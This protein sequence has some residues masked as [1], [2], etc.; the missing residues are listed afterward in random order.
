[1]D[2][3]VNHSQADIAANVSPSS[4]DIYAS[5]N[6]PD[7]EDNHGTLV[8]GVIGAGFNGFGTIGV[9]Y[10]S[11]LLGVRI[12]TP[13][14]CASGASQS[15]PAT[16]STCDF[17]PSDIARGIDYA[18]AN[19]AKVI[20]LS[21]GGPGGGL[22]SQFEAALSRAV[23]AGVVFT[24]SSGN[25]SKTDPDYPARYAIDPRFAGSILAVGSTDQNNLISSFSN[26]AGGSASEFVV[27]PGENVITGC[28]GTTCF[29]ASGTSFS[30]P[31][32]AGALALLLQAFP[33]LTGRQAVALLIQ[34]ADDL[35]PTGV[36]TTYGNG[37]ID[38]QR[39][40]APV[41][42]LSTP[43]SVGAVRIRE[44]L[45]SSLSGAFGDAIRRSSGLST[46]AYDS[47]N[48][49]YQVNL[50]EG[51]HSPPRASLQGALAPTATS[52]EVSIA[53]VP[54]VSLSLSTSRSPFIDHDPSRGLGFMATQ[55]APADMRVAIKAGAFS[56]QAW[57]GQGGVAPAPSLVASHDGF[58]GLA[59]ADHAAQVT[60]EV[61]GV[62]FGGEVGG[63]SRYTLYGLANLEP[64]HYA[65]ATAAV[66]SGSFA[67]QL[68]YGSLTEPQGPLGSFL[69]AIASSF[70]MPAS[71]RFISLRTDWVANRYWALSA[72]GSL[73]F[74]RA[75]GGLVGFDGAVT[76]STWRIVA[77]G[78]CDDS[79][80]CFSPLLQIDQP[81]RIERGQFK[82]TLAD[83]PANYDDP[84]QFSTRRFSA[85]PSGRQLN[86]RLGFDRLF[87][88]W[89]TF[90]FQG[91][92]VLDEANEAHAPLNTGVLASWRSKF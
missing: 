33:N 42:A 39:A 5:R 56:L 25:D 91:V 43:S 35:G 18:V 87:K 11:T 81:L 27:A 10:K 34:T 60:Y 71:T 7:G 1:M 8:A 3:G 40:F 70:G 75:A 54:G 30:A 57:R 22:G 45:G 58:A 61:G 55:E 26:L 28:D 72:E 37:L 16:K 86:V 66:H 46:I 49:L 68:S 41:G 51:F 79:G 4:T 36:D 74:T 19:G 14:S 59:R 48:R 78:R 21:L 92:M 89:G 15:P 6:V 12:D 76:S 84:L 88:D 23:A 62:T 32:V 73:G 69:P 29:R 63:A 53:A 50:A 90:Q 17:L 31:H 83:I 67:A 85:D 38:L 80:D 47:Y 77:H 64:S 52:S 20:N 24:I 82:A 2:S 44:Q 65:L 9:A 13:G